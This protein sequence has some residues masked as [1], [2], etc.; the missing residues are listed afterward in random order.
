MRLAVVTLLSVL[1]A[2]SSA[3]ASPR[4]TAVMLDALYR[5]GDETARR[6]Q[7]AFE[8]PR[9]W[10]VERR[11]SDDPVAGSYELR[12]PLAGRGTCVLKLNTRATAV[13]HAPDVRA[14]RLRIAA[15]ESFR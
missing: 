4:L 2:A 11:G 6:V 7:V 8:L 1:Y 9:S 10:L 3:V 14:G 5:D 12:V 15:T 13:A